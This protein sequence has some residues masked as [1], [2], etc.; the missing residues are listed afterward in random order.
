MTGRQAPFAPRGR[1]RVRLFTCGPSVYR[2]QHLGNYRTYL[3]EDVLQKYLEYRGHEVQR[4]INFT[5]VEDKA[6]DEAR[7]NG[8]AVAELRRP[9][10]EAFF[11]ECGWLGIAL[12]DT[13]PRAST[14]VEAAVDLV[15]RLLARG[16]AYWHEGQVFFDPL[17]YRGFGRLY[18]LDMSRWPEN[19]V[20]FR[21]DTY[22]GQRWNRG[23]FILWHKCPTADG[24]VCW[25]T[26]IGRGRPAWNI[27]DAAMIAKHMGFEIDLHTG[28]IDN[29]YRHHDYTLAVMEGASGRT[30]C[31]WWLHGGHL[32]V[33]GRK[34]SKSKDN[35]T[36]VDDLL[37]RGF[38]PRHIR[39]FL[40][41]GPY[42]DKLD[43][44]TV[45]LEQCAGRLDRVR[46]LIEGLRTRH[47]PDARAS[48]ADPA[49][50]IR[51]VFAKAMNDNLDFAGAFDAV[52]EAVC[53]AAEKDEA[54][55]MPPG[56]REA[57]LAA[58]HDVDRVFGVFR[59][60]G[61]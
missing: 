15:E 59:A 50:H 23:D 54:E 13:I 61:P 47:T 43:M 40:L 60:G 51:A 10:E 19:K 56:S 27:Q 37:R 12:P 41:Y 52:A 57:L 44:R 28:G 58:L 26:A 31:P 49:G 42:R 21:R 45:R 18:G 14:S 38:R 48:R 8:V 7:E 17:T 20:R 36:Y 30:F 53:R 4:V 9:V 25:D 55:G 33:D 24:Q 22:P 1:D 32:L 6:I 34:M 39:F 46:R 2:R 29:L 16:H 11:A 5:D 3:F 35:V